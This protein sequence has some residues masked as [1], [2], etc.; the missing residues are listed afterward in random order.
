MAAKTKRGTRLLFLDLEGTIFSKQRIKLRTGDAQEHHS[1]WSR[2]AHELGPEALAADAETVEKWEAGGYKS[3]MDWC[4]ESLRIH[5]RHGMT[6]ELFERIQ[7]SISYNAEVPETLAAIHARG[8]KTAIVAGGFLAQAR[9]AQQELEITHAYAAVDLFWNHEGRLVHW[10]I[11]PSDYEG[12]VDFVQLLIREYAL[13]R[14]ECAFIGDGKNDT[15]IA[16]EVGTSFAYRAH[17]DL[18][19]AATYTITDFSEILRYL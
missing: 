10:N 17:P 6:R 14:A 11:L 4:N 12:K 18:E 13:T 2:I 15:H 3:Y 9:R 1:L 7:T 5:Q 16:E 8:I 19:K